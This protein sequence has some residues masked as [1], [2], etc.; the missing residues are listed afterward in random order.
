LVRRY[1]LA[2]AQVR[3]HLTLD[4]HPS[5]RTSGLSFP[6]VL[7]EVFGPAVA[8]AMLPLGPLSVG[9]VEIRGFVTS[10]Q[11]T[12]G[13]RQHVTFIVHGRC[14]G[15]RTLA[16]AF[17]EGYRALLPRGRHPIAV[18][19]LSPPGGDVDVNVHPSKA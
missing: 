2:H 14:V 5:L 18:L 1:A 17:E 16:A 10:R 13:S 15:S 7:G 19:A 6:H 11:V 12:R 3:L 9:D 8:G 4:G